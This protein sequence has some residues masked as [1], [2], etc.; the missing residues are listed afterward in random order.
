MA[1]KNDDFFVEKKLWSKIKDRY[2]YNII[3]NDKITY[4]I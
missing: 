4:L 1:K 3:Y 2:Q